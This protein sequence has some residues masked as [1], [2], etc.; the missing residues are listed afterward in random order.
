MKKLIFPLMMSMPVIALAKS[1]SPIFPAPVELQALAR[2]VPP[3]E[4]QEQTLEQ[5]VLALTIKLNMV[6]KNYS[7]MKDAER[8]K[9]Q[10]NIQ[11][12]RENILK[13]WTIGQE[14]VSHMTLVHLN[15]AIRAYRDAIPKK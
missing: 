8:A 12:Q 9:E 14:V 4:N 5:M 6:A 7:S 2:Y 3:I 15:T 13:K 10:I 11:S 1:A